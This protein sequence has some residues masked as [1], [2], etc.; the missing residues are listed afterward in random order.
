MNNKNEGIEKNMNDLYNQLISEG[1][2]VFIEN[3]KLKAKSSKGHLDK[4]T[5]QIIKENK[6]ALMEFLQHKD[7]ELSVQ[8]I[9]K[10][11]SDNIAQLEV[12]SFAQQRLWFMD[13]LQG[14]SSEY[15]MPMALRVSGSLDLTLVEQVLSTIV[16]RHEVLRSVYVEEDGQVKQKIKPMSEVAVEVVQEEVSHLSGEAQAQAIDALLEDEFMRPFDLASDLMV[17]V[18]YV[19]TSQTSGVLLFNMHHIASDGWSMEVLNKEFFQ[20]YDALSQ[21]KEMPLPALDIQYADYAHWQRTY[22]E[23]E[24]LEQQLSYW[25]TQL[26]ELPGV[27]SLPLSYPR[28]AQKQ[29]KG[30]EVLGRLPAEVA[31]RLQA[32]ATRHQLS[33]FML[34]HGALSLLLA[35]HSNSADIVM[36]T[37]V[38]NRTQAE[39]SPLIGFFV[40]TLVLRADT[41]QPDLSS[42]F[43][44]IRQVHIDAQA[45]QD[46]PFEQ[47]VDR[48]KVHRS[49]AHSPLFQI[50]LTTDTDYGVQGG[51]ETITLPGVEL[52]PYA[53]DAVQA[54]FDLE[55][56]LSMS[57]AGVGLT[58][59]YDVSLFSEAAIMR[60]NDH[61]CR[62]LTQLSGVTSADIAPHEL[63]ILSEQEEQHL[64]LGLNQTVMPYPKQRCIHELFEQQAAEEPERV[65][66]V[67][68]ETVLSYGELNARANQ[69]AHYLREQYQLKPDTLVGLCVERSVEMVVG[70]LG[71]LKAGAAYVPLDPGYPSARLDYM[72]QDAALEVVLTQG[73]G[74]DVLTGFSG[75]IVAL[76]DT[77]LFAQQSSENIDKEQ[78]GLTANNLAYVIYTSGSTGQPK[79][80]MIEH[81]A[82][83]NYQ[84]HTQQAYGVTVSDRILQFSSISFDIFVEEF[85]G[86]LCHGA[87]LILSSPVCRQGLQEFVSYCEKHHVTIVSLPTAFWAQIVSDSKVF[88]NTS[89]RLVIVGGEA[90]STATVTEHYK[91]F[92]NEVLLMNTYGPTESTITATT[93]LTSQQCALEQSVA[94]GKANINNQLLI[95]D[96]NQNLVPDG[97]PGEL[98]IGGDGLAR[99]YLNRP[100]LTAER[101]INNPY[102][103][104]NEPGSSARLYRTGDLVRHLTDANLTFL[105]R[106]DEQVKIRGFRIELGE[107]EAQLAQL[108]GVDS[109]VVQAKGS[110]GSLHLVAYIKPDAALSKSERYSFIDNMKVKL[111][112]ELP[113][114]MV[115]STI[116]TVSEWPLTANGKIDK[117]SL[118]KPD[119]NVLLGEYVAPQSVIEQNLVDMWSTLL[120]IP[121]DKISTTANFFEL[122]GHSL[123]SIRLIA[124]LRQQFDVDLP[125]QAVFDAE[126]LAVLATLVVSTQRRSARP[127]LTAIVRSAE[128]LPVSFAQQRLWFI[129]KL[130]G[131]SSE[132]NMP[133]ALRVSGSL[134]LTLVEQV[135]STIVARHE[136]LRS[137]YVEEDG[138]V[139]QKIKPMSEVAVEVVQEEVSHLSG[140]AQAQAID[141]LL[142]DEF[143][144]PFDLASDLMV[145]VHYVHTSQT[146]G[147]LLFNMHHIASDGWSMEV[148][149]K[150][151]FQLYDA[152]SQ[153]KEMPLPALDIQYADY[154]HWQ[155]TYLEG[156][157]LEQQLS[158]WETQLSELP[159]MHSLPLSYPRPAQKQYKGAEVLGRLPAEVA[160]RLQALATRHQLSPFM[161]LHGALSL[162]LARHSN[163]ADIVMGTPVANRTQAELSPL[164][165]FFVNT[166]VLRADTA[167]PDLSSYFRH[168]RQV[169]IDAQANQD[170]PFEQL[171][172]RLKVHRSAAHSPLFQI[173]LT[174]DTD[175]GVQGGDETI[176]LPGVEL[177]PYAN[178][179]VQ[180][181][182]DL[183]VNLSMSEAGVGLTWAYDVSLFS[184][185]A[186]MRLNDHLCRLLTQ[187]SGVTSAD[188]APHELTILSEQEEQH[189]LLGLNQTVMPY[190]K[191]R[192]IHELFEQQAAEEPERVAVVLD[193]T[194][195]SYGELN[196]RANQVAHYLR[197]QYQLKPDTLV[198]LCVERSVEMVVGILGILKAGAAYV[199]L[200]PGYPSAR[201]DYMVQDAALEVVLTQGAGKDVLTGFSGD[202]V[203]LDDTALFAQQSSENIDKEQLGL[204]ANNL[205]YVIYTSGSTGQPKG[206]MIEHRALM[207]FKAGFNAQLALCDEGYKNGWLWLSSFIFDASLKGIVLLSKGIKLI[208]PNAEQV[209]LPAELAKIV[210]EHR[211]SVLNATPQLLDMVIKE[212]TLPRVDLISSGEA[213]GVA[214]QHFIAF[215]KHHGSVLINGY[216]PTETTVNCAFSVLS[217]YEGEVIGRAT[218]NTVFYILNEDQQLVPK[219]C[220]G[221][222]FVSGDGL[223]RGYLNRPELTAGR[224]IDNPYHDPSDSNSGAR[225]YRTGDLVRY[226]D[227]GN[228][229]FIGRADDQVKIR[230]FRIELGEVEAQLAQHSEVDSAFVQAITVAGN[231]QLVGYIKPTKTLEVDMHHDLI[232]AVKQSLGE[233]LPEYMVPSFLIVIAQW[234]LTANGKLDKKALPKADVKMLLGEYVAPKTRLERLLAKIWSELLH[235][236]EDKISRTA[237]FFELGGHSLLTVKLAAEIEQQCKMKISLDKLFKAATVAA[238]ARLC[239]GQSVV[240]SYHV[241]KPI[242]SM[243][244]NNDKLFMIPG[245]ASTENDFAWLATQL[246]AYGYRAYACPHKGL[247]DGEQ[248]YTSLTEN[249][250]AVAHGINQY[251]DDQTP[252]KLVGHSF[253]GLLALETANELARTG[254]NVEVILIDCYFEQHLQKRK[255]VKASVIEMT[256]DKSLP[257]DVD[258][259]FIRQIQKL[260]KIQ[261]QW[262]RDYLPKVEPEVT[263]K[264]IYATQSGYCVDTYHSYFQQFHTKQVSQASID[265]AHME[266]LKSESLVEQLN[267][268]LM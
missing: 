36:G 246:S 234:P 235:I 144:R 216:G 129:D 154:A 205:A 61:L 250:V 208:I 261:S 18:H 170:V 83:L 184:E 38:A 57:E 96:D 158:Y 24:V 1:A 49:A 7:S 257:S 151:F 91:S 102:Y 50:M 20:L 179:A 177:A 67:L 196:A 239:E 197:E 65:A 40:N 225:L 259:V 37:P 183:E 28:P 29:Y 186:I 195:L 101:F 159:G 262:F 252:I 59:A 166:L 233:R 161:L 145:R 94:I 109:A 162:L 149:N 2:L 26:S 256:T 181:K 69:V 221:E 99:G 82:L 244:G 201:L 42:Y 45:N 107:V 267:T 139:K 8:K 192:C 215:T 74:K 237:N 142:E 127:P 147:V 84:L 238:M 66:V 35:R 75:D 243:Q 47:L 155:R 165:G 182:F 3:G 9:K 210:R 16:A 254:L 43:R 78:L 230:G 15:N 72:V 100:E 41:A 124:A 212:P 203:A 175:Y 5:V 31:Q 90:L 227:D 115:P 140:E 202:I 226:L 25:E 206:V 51:D 113:E 55:V 173:M 207:N 251:S 223:A 133:M 122:G 187:L 167:Q 194:V 260:N 76:D 103:N 190:P 189:L 39:L 249:I 204:T 70:I 58:W 114:Y 232:S 150:E 86:A 266:I 157:V 137:V 265:A 214:L 60:L 92:P 106:T 228:L 218:A 193:E 258:E 130:Q 13:K 148:L 6:D 199:P 4:E 178:D 136:V 97:V 62:L 164:I 23:G 163:S 105:G 241:V 198:G 53:N 108:V 88:T 240:N 73:A 89:I 112:E 143:M 77:A 131:G 56:N 118:P 153:G 185:A 132:Y 213:M 245:V 68:D 141:A 87:Q 255:E 98:Y 85:F 63:T 180:A 135:L 117:K 191:Q 27:H 81:R 11:N 80:V 174:T 217:E 123:L 119:G 104:P 19:H 14:G 126:S 263:V 229:E 176:T 64:L 111:K 12:C 268:Y 22:L 160:Q 168:I 169:H 247:L 30:A 34:L 54:K 21:G 156:E 52:A 188:I 79:G 128:T 224:F 248:P 110:V 116:M 200:D 95:L 171:V 48:L 46:V 134:D 32:L 138:Q 33:P 146:S 264:S 121:G 242:S 219:G 10:R 231:P 93:Y 71:I 253:G 44:H 172:D 152:L 209:K 120:E 125:V 236:E 17:R 220:V 222:L 211:L